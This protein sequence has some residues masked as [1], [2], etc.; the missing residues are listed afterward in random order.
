MSDLF[1][2]E[3]CNSL[4]VLLVDAV[5][6]PDVQTALFVGAVLSENAVISFNCDQIFLT[7]FSPDFRPSSDDL[8]LV[9]PAMMVLPDDYPPRPPR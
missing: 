4:G 8:N 7:S 9:A 6:V 1:F 5:G 2:N 3:A